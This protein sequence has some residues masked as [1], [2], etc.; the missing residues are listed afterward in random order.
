MMLPVFSPFPILQTER[1]LLRR[2]EMADAPEIFALRSSEKLMQYIDRP[3]AQS[4]YDARA[5]IEKI[6]AALAKN[7][8]ITWGITLKDTHPVVGTAGFWRLDKEN[9][10]AEIGYMLQ[11]EQQGKGVMKE[12]LQAIFEYGFTAMQLHSVE[13]NTNTDNKASQALLNYFGFK[14]EALFRENYYYD[15]RFLD[16]A[17]FSLLVHEFV[18]KER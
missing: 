14:Q 4:E 1:L 13:A 6:E 17:I 7:D 10:R 5:L 2:I 9:Y 12:A 8:G 3:L 16:S 11:E 15:G 18:K